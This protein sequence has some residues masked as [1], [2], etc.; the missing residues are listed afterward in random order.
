M[1][2][3]KYNYVAKV[4]ASHERNA[5][6]TLILL[7]WANIDLSVV[8][9]ETSV[10][11]FFFKVFFYISITINYIFS[12][13]LGDI[14]LKEI[15]CRNVTISVIKIL[16]KV[17]PLVKHAK[18]RWKFN[19]FLLSNTTGK[20]CIHIIHGGQE[21]LLISSVYFVLNL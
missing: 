8:S 21:W 14:I 2:N 20:R 17:P 10:S 5:I 3:P 18:N 6:W 1:M 15:A 4:H 7:I 13:Q 16:W 9:S 19:M 11:P 12:F